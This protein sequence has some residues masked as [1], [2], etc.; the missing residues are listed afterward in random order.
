MLCHDGG[1]IKITHATRGGIRAPHG[2]VWFAI[3]AD[4][5]NGDDG[6]LR[7]HGCAHA[8]IASITLCRWI[9]ASH[10]ARPR[11]AMSATPLLVERLTK[12][13]GA[14][15]AVNEVSF[16]VQSGILRAMVGPN[17]VGKSSLLH[18]ILGTSHAE[19]RPL[20]IFGQE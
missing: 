7:G 1:T 2:S 3:A 18:F 12:C 13:Y 5:T 14:K 6:Q 20:R 4:A 19:G 15:V 9:A 11:S 10:D 17:G 8:R 16:V